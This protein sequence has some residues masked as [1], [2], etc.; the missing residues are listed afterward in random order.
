MNS[1][2]IDNSELP[3]PTFER[4]QP[5]RLGLVELYHY[6]V[7]E[8]WFAD[9]HLL[10]RGNNGTG[11]SKVLSLTLPFLLDADLSPTRIE[12]DA[13]RG[14]RMEW[15][16]LMGGR[17]ERRTGYSWIEFGRIEDGQPHFLTLGAGLRAT[18][19][20]TS[21]DP[22]FF[23]TDRRI[24]EDFSLVS[25]QQTAL[26]R[27]RL[28]EALGA[29]A[30]FDT[31]RDYR[32]T[33]DERLFGLGVERY[34]A[35]ADTLIQLRQP[36]LSKQPDESNLSDALSNAFPP[37]ERSVLEDVADAMN[38][39][40]EYREELDDY[41]AMHDAVARFNGTYSRYAQILAR[42]Q[43][44][45]LRQAQTALDNASAAARQ[46]QSELETAKQT[47][48]QCEQQFRHTGD[49]L[50]E[51]GGQLE[52]LK[53]SPEMRSADQLHR[54]QSEA[55]QAES[56][57]EQAGEHH[58][59][60]RD[61]LEQEQTVS[62]NRRQASTAA[63]EALTTAMDALAEQ[64]EAIGVRTSH[65]AT[66]GG[67]TT[68]EALAALDNKARAN[69]TAA[70]TKIAEQRRK[71]I[72]RIRQL[73]VACD[74][75]R[76][77][78]AR[79]QSERD[80]RLSD[81]EA[82]EAQANDSRLAQSDAAEAH[83]QAWQDFIEKA[84]EPMPGDWPDVREALADWVNSLEGVSPLDRRL[85]EAERTQ[86]KHLAEL[87]S[88]LRQRHNTLER[89]I[90]PLRNEYA[91]LTEGR[92]PE[93]PPP[94][95]RAADRSERP[96]APLWKVVEFD[97]RLDVADRAGLEAALQASGLLDAWVTPA[98]QILD[99]DTEDTWL[100]ARVPQNENLGQVLRVAIDADN[101]RSS[102]LDTSAVETA[103]AAI[104]LGE[105]DTAE[106]WVA[107]DGRYRLGPACGAWHKDEAEYI[108]FAAREAARRR[109]LEKLAAEIER[110]QAELA[111]IS[112]QR[113]VLDRQSAALDAL[114]DARPEAEDLRRAHA[115]LA[116]AERRAAG[117]R[118]RLSEA[119][120]GLARAREAL[121]Q[122]QHELQE[123]AED[124]HLPTEREQLDSLE[125]S[126]SE[127]RHAV[128]T[129][130]ARLREQ[131]AART[132]LANQ[133]QREAAVEAECERVR[134]QA[135][136][137]RH[138]AETSRARADELQ[139][140]LGD[141]AEAVLT[142]ISEL[143]T[144]Q[145]E[146][147]AAQED[148]RKQLDEALQTLGSAESNAESAEGRREEQAQARADAVASFQSFAT[149][150]L[151]HA[152]VPA[153]ELPD[154][155]QPWAVDP[156]LAAARETEQALH[157][158]ADGDNDLKRVRDH[159]SSEYNELAR[160]L[161]A[162]GY[163]CSGELGDHGFMV[164]VSFNQ[165]F[166]APDQIERLLDTEIT[167]RR[168]LL[169]AKERE[170]IEN[171]LQA[172]VAA[173]LQALMREA[174]DRVRNINAELAKRPTTTGVKFK[175]D[176]VARDEE[177]ATELAGIADAR[178]RL[179][180][181][182][183]DA[184]SPEDRQI[185]GDFLQ[186][187]IA[188]ERDRDDGAA[189]IDQL[190]RALDY[191]GWHRF[192]VRRWQ[193]G[194]WRPLSGPASSG[195]RALGLTVPLFAAA[196]SHYESASDRAP[197]LVLMDEAFAGIDDAA[198]AHCMAL[199]REFDLD[200]VMTSEREWGCY[201]ELPGVSICHLVRREDVEAVHVSRWWWNGRTREP[202]PEPVSA[203]AVEPAA[204]SE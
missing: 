181:T 48:Q 184:W 165:R 98:G 104:A 177:D 1:T 197:R 126:L 73:L 77:E 89:E 188:A 25:E 194:Q 19:G 183:S 13:D 53:A 123:D 14:K 30:V 39:L 202:G 74:K 131:A 112:K 27:E 159:L 138:D 67:H 29:H 174:D 168:N 120:A 34:R 108:G 23:V 114:M 154:T 26:T 164:R 176:W 101:E 180:N 171:H 110:L 132:E 179:I 91:E 122:A 9:G 155:S 36:Q 71:Q 10:L 24:G 59:R 35:L 189:R 187:R 72:A 75:A 31:A 49:R 43:A 144:S 102:H 52:A 70:Q 20:R 198:R 157:S 145:G 204:T 170:I 173:Q 128:V 60:Q 93:P 186:Q 4:W 151:L 100:I 190:A 142:R 115:N 127:Y 51:I 148:Q 38:Q 141:S 195:E 167:E 156:A 5:L 105:S 17:F 28:T 166:E 18:A 118:D 134:I 55:R 45:S 42:R 87:D 139:R 162:R 124:T 109:R 97:D 107:T 172:E 117:A 3:Q 160:A 94:Q 68:P 111:E 169:T 33:V 193:D 99:P 146:L 116:A 125:Q 58:Q 61:S 106:A 16:L 15:N 200:F 161:S 199:I 54:A 22:W 56:R 140:S 86:R 57:A 143:E 137:A 37:L 7:E 46:A 196:S 147:N 12:P 129:T 85:D 76:D 2:N 135:E 153:I 150:E 201:S 121:D 32:R 8:F 203:L 78:H 192:R 136:Q 103:L 191:R 6:D 133:L 95:T 96:G 158:V 65:D 178:K 81:S 69:I 47:K 113:E 83:I 82:A 149:T 185:V 90:E 182:A 175:L 66:W 41:R 44:R 21:V 63:D 88:E 163:E 119:E 11:K 40:D 62:R 64:A 84:R 152:A 50:A 92:Q 79:A 80:A 130:E